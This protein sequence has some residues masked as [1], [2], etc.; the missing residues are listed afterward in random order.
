MTTAYKLQFIIGKDDFVDFIQ[1]LL[2]P[3]PVEYDEIEA[4]LSSNHDQ[5]N[6]NQTNRL[7]RVV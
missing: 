6:K 7:T 4:K 5:Y 3:P 1:S 2:P